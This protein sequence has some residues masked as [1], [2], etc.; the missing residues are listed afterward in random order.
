MFS[1]ATSAGIKPSASSKRRPLHSVAGLAGARHCQVAPLSWLMLQ[2][3]IKKLAQCKPRHDRRRARKSVLSLALGA[4]SGLGSDGAQIARSPHTFG[5]SPH[6]RSHND[7]PSAIPYLRGLRAHTN[8]AMS[9][10]RADSLMPRR[11][12][13][14]TYAHYGRRII[15]AWGKVLRSYCGLCP[16]PRKCMEPRQVRPAPRTRRIAGTPVH[17]RARRRAVERAARVERQ[18]GWRQFERRSRRAAVDPQR[19][20][21]QR[22]PHGCLG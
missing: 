12:L 18:F 8:G 16:L 5:Q 2:Q 17:R 9:G 11:M 15:L 4:S 6:R 13:I 22:F 14:R 1:S 7:Q 19:P 20:M 3:P 10:E 21:R